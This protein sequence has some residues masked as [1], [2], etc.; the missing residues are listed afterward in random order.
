MFCVYDRFYNQSFFQLNCKK[1]RYIQRMLKC[2]AV[3]L[4]KFF[5]GYFY[6]VFVLLTPLV[7]VRLISRVRWT[8]FC[9]SCE[10]FCLFGGNF[11]APDIYRW[12]S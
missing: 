6:F 11:F 10:P 9:L 2:N 7:R 5:F 12:L 1:E 3:G 8:S 4:L